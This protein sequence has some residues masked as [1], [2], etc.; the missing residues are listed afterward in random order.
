[1][2][3]Q[4]KILQAARPLPSFLDI[5][6]EIVG[7]GVQ[8][9]KGGDHTII[10]PLVSPC[11][12]LEGHLDWVMAVAFS[13]DGKLVASASAN[14]TVRLWDYRTEMARYTLSGHSDTVNFVVFSPDGKLLASASE[15]NTIRLWDTAT[16]AMCHTLNSS[17]GRVKVEPFSMRPLGR[18]FAMLSVVTFSPDGKLAMCASTDHTVKLWNSVTGMVHHTLESHLNWV[19]DVAFSPDGK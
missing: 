12:T 18:L 14:E 10:Y 11:R 16:G 19:N 5:E 17:L 7:A 13:P 15:G 9:S 1:L 6:K 2:V 3:S 4:C 8:A